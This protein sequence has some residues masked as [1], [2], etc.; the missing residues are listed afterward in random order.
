MPNAHEIAE[1]F[2]ADFRHTK[3]ALKRSGY[4]R[5]NKDGAEADWDLFAEELGVAFFN[6]V[7]ASGIAKTLIDQPPRKL[8]VTLDW[9]PPN[10]PPLTNVAQLMI[11][12]MCRVRNSYIHGEKFV[13]ARTINAMP[14]WWLR[15]MRF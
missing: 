6:H 7:K 1:A 14:P 2:A 13:G 9:S 15:L 3:Y 12:G 8:L 4:L 5:K 11:N 10:P